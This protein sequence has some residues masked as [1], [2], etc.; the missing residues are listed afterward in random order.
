MDKRLLEN[1]YKNNGYYDVKILNS[2]AEL[3]DEDGSF[4]LS[5]NID[6]GNKFFFNDFNLILSDDYDEED[7]SNINKIFQ[8]LKREQY[9]LDN[10]NLILS[11]IDY[12]ASLKL[13]DF[14]NVEVNERIVDENKIWF[15]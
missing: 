3:N 10:I 4:K 1:F 6:A 7:F 5:F 14:I 15:C 12:I 13:Y 11:E 8:K 2:F 9:S